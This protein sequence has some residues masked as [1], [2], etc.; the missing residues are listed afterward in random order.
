MTS[1]VP[2][3]PELDARKLRQHFTR[4]AAPPHFPTVLPDW[5]TARAFRTA[6]L[7]ALPGSQQP[8]ASNI[9]WKA[10]AQ[11][12]R[13][14]KNLPEHSQTLGRKNGGFRPPQIGRV[15]SAL[16]I[17]PMKCRSLPLWLLRDVPA[18]LGVMFSFWP[19]MI[20]VIVNG[21]RAASGKKVRQ[22]SYIDFAILLAHA[23]ARLAFALWRQAYRRLGWDQRGV[24]FHL[25]PASDNF[26]ATC[27]RYHAYSRACREIDA[28]VDAYVED[29]RAQYNI[30]E[31]EAANASG[32]PL[33]RAAHVAYP[34]RRCLS[35]LAARRERWIVAS[36][37]RDGGGSHSSRGPPI[38]YSQRATRSNHLARPARETAPACQNP[39]PGWQKPRR[40]EPSG[41]MLSADIRQIS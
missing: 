18:F 32:C 20:L 34:S 31:R 4:I 6:R 41:V 37:R 38:R 24:E 9:C 7:S 39:N 11:T 36:S 15:F 2:W 40:A 30:S 33:R 16:I 23:E 3:N 29:L 35:S 21:R 19:L 17:A 28:Y 25:I 5:L 26:D 8:R 12:R 14:Q 1:D 27:E 13:T 10:P 22:S